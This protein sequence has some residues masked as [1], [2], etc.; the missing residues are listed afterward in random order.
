MILPGNAANRMEP[1][2]SILMP[3]TLSSLVPDREA[4][5]VEHWLEK[6]EEVEM[7]SR[8]RGGAYA[9]GATQGAPQAQQCADR[10]HLCSNLGE[11]VERFLIRTQAHLPETQPAEAGAFPPLSFSF[12]HTAPKG[13]A[14]V[15]PLC[16]MRRGVQGRAEQ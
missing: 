11:A 4:T 5:T 15:P 13:T 14:N 6:H 8:D 2:L 1:F 7:V 10:W 9:D 3:M 16:H 12:H